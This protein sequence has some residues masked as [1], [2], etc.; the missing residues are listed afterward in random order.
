MKL[1]CYGSLKRGKHNHDCLRGAE[2][3]GT[4]YIGK[5]Y[6][7]YVTMLP[8]LVR[9]RGGQGVL[10]ELYEVNE[11]TLRLCDYLEGHPIFYTRETVWVTDADSGQEIEAATYLYHHPIPNKLEPRREYV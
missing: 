8:Y 4:A 9:E 1:F 6:N 3:L 11:E 7:M 2:F 10:G 5:G